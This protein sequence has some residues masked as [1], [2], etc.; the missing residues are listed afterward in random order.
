MIPK[1][2]HYVWV[3]GPMPPKQKRFI[4]SWREHNPD[5]DFILWNED[6]IDFSIPAIA[7]AY[8]KKLW[9]KVAD[10]VRLKVV[11]EMGGVYLDTDFEVFRPLD[12]LLEHS[13]FFGF[14]SEYPASDWIGTGA[15]GA[16]PGHWFVRKAYDKIISLRD[17]PFGLERPTKF[18][19]KLI[20]KMLCEEG[21]DKYYAEGTTVNDIYIYSTDAFYPFHWT[22]EFSTDCILS[23][24]FAAHFWE[25]SWKKDVP[26]VLRAGS[27]IYAYIRRFS[28]A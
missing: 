20:T 5:F 14:Q 9:A 15:F 19:P 6:N 10:I 21:L 22:E 2:I 28:K 3:G 13:C 24:T 8:Q 4:E 17:A 16:V 18:G 27:A 1:K 26:A 7:R 25:K 12:P 23:N 11:S